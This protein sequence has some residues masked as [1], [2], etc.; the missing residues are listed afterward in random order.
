M[1]SLYLRSYDKVAKYKKPGK[2][3]VSN[4][5]KDQAGLKTDILVGIFC[6]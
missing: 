5:I 2:T 4:G 6:E 1:P 3:F